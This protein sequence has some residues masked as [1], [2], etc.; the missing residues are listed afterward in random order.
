LIFVAPGT[1]AKG[2]LCEQ[3]VDLTSVYPTLCSL[4]GLDVPDHIEGTSITPLLSNPRSDWS[5]PAVTTHGR[6]NHAVRMGKWRYIR[7]AD[8][9]QELYDHSNDEYE[10]N[11][12]ASHS[13]YANV[14]SDLAQYLPEH[15]KAV[16]A[17]PPLP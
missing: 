3:P 16:S 9:S 12:L 2:A 1:T 10:W 6:G 15:E 17:R 7:Y 8:G 11:N 14:M 5:L 13:D 4:A